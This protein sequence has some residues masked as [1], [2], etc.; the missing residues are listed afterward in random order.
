MDSAYSLQVNKFARRLRHLKNFSRWYLLKKYFVVPFVNFY[1][2]LGVAVAPLS[3]F[4]HIV[5]PLSPSKKLLWQT[6]VLSVAI[7]LTNSIASFSTINYAFIAPGSQL[8][9]EASSLTSDVLVADEYGYLVKINPQ[10]GESNRE[11]MNDFA[12]HTVESGETLSLIAGNYGVGMETIMWQN[13][14]PNVNSIRT[15]QKLMVPPVDGVSYRVQKGDSLEKIATKY[16]IP[17]NSIAAQNAL[18]ESGVKIG[19]EVFLPGAK[20]LAPT[21]AN[22]SQVGVSSRAAVVN[23]SYRAGTFTANPST[24]APAVGRIFIYPTRGKVTQGYRAGHYALDI[25][26]R[27]MPAVWAAGGGTVIKSST[28]TWGGG[29]G[30]HVVIDH[31]NG[32]QTLYAHMNTVN[33]GVGQYVNQGDVIGQMGNTG[34]VYGATGIH[35]HWEVIVNGVKQYPGNYY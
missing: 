8:L 24:D 26:D 18:G 5:G 34:R 14:L 28:G 10:T 12:V 33:V 4:G 29:Y 3:R 32:V 1:A 35:L 22:V 13:N 21:I 27:S 20:P 19:Q 9:S 17:A 2:K 15:G 30:N 6:A 11:G 25:A 7:V 16:A 23:R 31:G